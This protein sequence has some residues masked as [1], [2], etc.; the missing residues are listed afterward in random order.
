MSHASTTP[1]LANPLRRS[2][3][4]PFGRELL[5]SSKGC[6][7][8]PFDPAPSAPFGSI[9]RGSEPNSLTTRA[10]SNAATRVRHYSHQLFVRLNRRAGTAD[11]A[12][13]SVASALTARFVLRPVVARAHLGRPSSIPIIRFGPVAAVP[14]DRL[15]DSSAQRGMGY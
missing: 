10:A 3:C 6:S 5:S 7:F 4:V 8:Q 13:P 1:V 9:D 2:S 15:A 12:P 14:F 11:S